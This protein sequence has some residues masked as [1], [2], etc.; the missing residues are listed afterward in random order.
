MHVREVAFILPQHSSAKNSI[1]RFAPL[2]KMRKESW[3]MYL[4]VQ[5]GSAYVKYEPTFLHT[6][7]IRSLE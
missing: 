3:N 2:V 5:L 1:A 4:Y 7:Q 6:S